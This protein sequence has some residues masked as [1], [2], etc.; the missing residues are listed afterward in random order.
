MDINATQF[1]KLT[2]IA[3][4]SVSHIITG[5]N[6]ISLD[7][8]I[9]IHQAFPSINLDWLLFGKGEM[10]N[11]DLSAM[12]SPAQQKQNEAMNYNTPQDPLSLFDSNYAIKPQQNCQS[13]PV[14][15]K[16]RYIEKPPRKIKEV[17]I[18]FDDGT[19]ETLLSSK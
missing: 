11:D 12:K 8:V 6:K 5:R 1:A 4:A 2:Q 18:F 17:W 15:E 3:P 19:Y 13:S 14:E 9:K 16:I 7:I 10:Y